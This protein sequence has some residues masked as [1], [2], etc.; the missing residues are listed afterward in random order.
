MIR[1]SSYLVNHRLCL[2][3]TWPARLEL[4]RLAFEDVPMRARVT[5]IAV[6]EDQGSIGLDHL[7]SMIASAWDSHVEV[8]AGCREQP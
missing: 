1:A 7:E 8:R 2:V 5:E 3:G 4:A 6:P